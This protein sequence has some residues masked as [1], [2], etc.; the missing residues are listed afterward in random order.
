MFQ[1]EVWSHFFPGRPQPHLVNLYAW[2]CGYDEDGCWDDAR[3]ARA[4]RMS[5]E[6]RENAKK[7]EAARKR[8][9]VNARREAGQ[10]QHDASTRP[11]TRPPAATVPGPRPGVGKTRAY[12]CSVCRCQGHKARRKEGVAQCPVQ[13]PAAAASS[14]TSQYGNDRGKA[15]AAVDLANGGGGKEEEDDDIIVEAMDDDA[16][17]TSG[18][19]PE[20]R[21][22]L[23]AALATY[24]RQA[25]LQMGNRPIDTS[26]SQQQQQ[27]Q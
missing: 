8:A 2:E 7:A 21:T 11:A 19:R 23:A 18:M 13:Q 4:L 5:R 16:L 22:E 25:M 14:S 20:E 15:M 12:T 17:D 27:Q 24:D 26:T 10:R 1:F 3:A 9:A 6:E